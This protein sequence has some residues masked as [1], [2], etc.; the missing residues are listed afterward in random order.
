[1][2]RQGERDGRESVHSDSS[3]SFSETVLGQ[4]L[5]KEGL[6][7]ERDF[8]VE[9]KGS[10]KHFYATLVAS[11]N[12]KPP[13]ST[14]R[15][16][17]RATVVG[18]ILPTYPTAVDTNATSTDFDMMAGRSQSNAAEA[19]IFDGDDLY[20]SYTVSESFSKRIIFTFDP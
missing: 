18:S 8:E 11:K 13:Q 6:I 3:V 7:A 14:F 5:A 19:S 20:L 10:K 12:K 9:C 15:R 2:Q 4:L 1:M 16:P 17:T